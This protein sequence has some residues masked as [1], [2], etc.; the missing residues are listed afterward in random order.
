MLALPVKV[1]Y[2]TD[3]LI[4]PDEE[5]LKHRYVEGIEDATGHTIF[6][7][8]SGYFKVSS[9]EA[10]YLADMMNNYERVKLLLKVADKRVEAKNNILRRLNYG[11]SHSSGTQ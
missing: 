9:E 1:V 6:Y 7:T 4:D 5:D 11:A 8:E 10:E 2:S 3:Y